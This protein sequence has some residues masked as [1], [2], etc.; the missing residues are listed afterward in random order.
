MSDSTSMTLTSPGRIG[1]PGLRT[2]TVVSE[3]A[4][5]V[6]LLPRTLPVGANVRIK[7]R[8]DLTYSGN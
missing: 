1:L 2:A 3:H 7:L 6:Q 5:S 4:V 8:D